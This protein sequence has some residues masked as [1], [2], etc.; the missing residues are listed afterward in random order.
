V[1]GIGSQNCP[2][3][4][5]WG[6]RNPWSWSFDRQT[7]ELWVGDVGNAVIEEVDRVVRGGNYGWRCYEGSGS[8]GMS[9]GSQAS[10]TAPIAQYG[11]SLGQSITGGYVYRGAT[12]TAL[13]GRYLFGD[14]LS[15]RIWSI[16]NNAQPT[17]DMDNGYSSGLQISAFGQD[18]NGEVY[19]LHYDDQ[20]GAIYQIV[21]Q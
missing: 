6:F 19:V 15:G 12:V 16:A 5:A 7:G 2:E 4:Y 14:Y 11:R 13:A 3:I 21:S 10:P 9:C 8:T 20:A 17:L 1:N 18:T